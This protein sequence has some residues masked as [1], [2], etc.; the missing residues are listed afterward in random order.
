[1]NFNL[2][3]MKGLNEIRFIPSLVL[4]LTC[5][6]SPAC[7]N[8]EYDLEKE[9]NMNVTVLR[10]IA[11]PVG[12]FEKVTLDKLLDF[13]GDTEMLEIDDDGNMAIT[14]ADASTKLKQTIM[15]PDFEISSSFESAKVQANIGD[16]YIAYDP[17]WSGI[18]DN[19]LDVTQPR[20]FSSPLKLEISFIDENFPKQIK[21]I[22]YAEIDA[23]AS[24]SLSVKENN[25]NELNLKVV[26]AAGT[27]IEFPDWV[28]FGEIPS[29]FSNEGNVLTLQQDIPFQMG[30][31]ANPYPQ[32]LDFHVIGLDASKLPQGQGIRTDGTLLMED[33]IT[34]NGL[35][36]LDISELGTVDPVKISPLISAYFEFSDIDINSI[37]VLFGDDI[38]IDLVSG[39]SPVTFNE[40]PDFLS[41]KDVVLDLADI[42]LDIDFDNASPFAG[43]L[44]AVIESST[45]DKLI[46]QKAIGPVNFDAAEN[47]VPAQMRWSFSEGTIVPPYGYIQ[48][49]VPGLTELIDCMPKYLSIKEFSFNLSKE[50]VKIVPGDRY[51]LSEQY[52][53]Y[54]PIAFGPQFRL[55]Y[56]Y[57][58]ENIDF[59]FSTLSIPSARLEL[60]VESTVP[61]D[62]AA[63]AKILGYDSEVVEGLE[64]K[65]LDG[66]VLKAGTLENPVISNL[67]IEL[68]NT[69]SN[70]FSFD[71]LELY[72]NA[73]APS[74]GGVQTLNVNQGLHVKSIVIRVPD[75]ISMDLNEEF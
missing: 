35:A 23:H 53:V 41:S 61:L 62:F 28:V 5:L 40:L 21:D 11:L 13:S 31:S 4:A 32:N 33:Y 54:A 39:L 6:L 52:A 27:S 46:A 25:N 63:E 65:I 64:L 47:G 43:T 74:V 66:A 48:Y 8:E 69:G 30:T 14:F 51:V 18:L 72:L 7:V 60:Q 36:Y 12:S 49:D 38:D 73:S 42:R 75:G 10:D 70:G 34:I 24:M 71:A 45:D 22:G 2:T 56:T 58:I 15:V 1:M 44:S 9:I 37:E 3:D 16:F 67:S 29:V 57:L 26:L 50:F 59:N 55:P 17:S 20:E 19:V 68:S